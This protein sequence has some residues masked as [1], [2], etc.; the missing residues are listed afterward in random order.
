[1]RSWNRAD[2]WIRH[3]PALRVQVYDGCVVFQR[4]GNESDSNTGDEDIDQTSMTDSQ[5]HQ[6]PSDQ[7]QFTDVFETPPNTSAGVNSGRSEKKRNAR[8][9]S[10]GGS[11]SFGDDDISGTA[12]SPSPKSGTR[13]VKTTGVDRSD[14][15]WD[16]CRFLY[17][18]I[19]MVPRGDEK[20]EMLIGIQQMIAGTRRLFQG[21][22]TADAVADQLQNYAPLFICTCKQ[23]QQPTQFT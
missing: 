16:F 1:M 22:P 14:E 8:K 2:D 13:R 6:Q 18:K 21:Q 4:A 15:D 17:H 23:N 12:S 11:E 10:H 7:E 3:G 9:R 5:T 20:E 19:K